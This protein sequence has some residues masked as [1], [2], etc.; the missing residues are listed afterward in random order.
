M[1]NIKLYMAPGSCTTA[2][3]I[4]LEEIGEFFE[5]HIVN[6]PK[7]DHLTPDYLALNPKGTIPT[8][9]RRD[10]SALTETLAI[11]FWLARTSPRA[12]LWF[13]D[14]T[15]EARALEIV[16]H[17]T[18]TTHGQGFARVFSAGA[19]A[20]DGQSMEAT[21]AMG[22][23]IVTRSFEWLDSVVTPDAFALGDY[24]VVDPILFYVCFWARKT[25]IPLPGHL[26]AHFERM[27]HRAVVQRVLREEGYN[28]E[29]LRQP[30][31]AS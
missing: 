23:E 12:G 31:L 10:G 13:D 22:R 7:G 18:A 1:G 3:H 4:L 28:P 24:S 17:V 19:F 14:P 8:L 30:D 2:I 6:L 9:V 16:G 20:K 26:A 25:E 21:Q 27:L 5:A 11:A 15:Q 29:K